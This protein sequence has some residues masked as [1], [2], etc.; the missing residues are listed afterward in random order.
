MNQPTKSLSGPNLPLQ[1][2]SNSKRRTLADFRDLIFLERAARR[3][4]FVPIPRAV[5][6]L[7]E[8]NAT[9]GTNG[10]AEFKGARGL[11]PG[12]VAWNK[13]GATLSPGNESGSG[14]RTADGRSVML[15]VDQRMAMHFGSR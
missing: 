15:M 6:R 12:T 5:T 3:A 13:N 1:N 2:G 10:L 9:S 4:C 7:L 8:S 11:M 14:N